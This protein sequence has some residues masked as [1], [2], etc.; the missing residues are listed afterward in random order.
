VKVV[1]AITEPRKGFVMRRSVFALAVAAFAA[2]APYVRGDDPSHEELQ[3]QIRQLQQRVAE[4]ERTQAANN[5]GVQA[6]RESV[7]KDASERSRIVPPLTP[8]TGGYDK[9]FFIRS[10]DGHYTLRPG[11]QFQ[12]RNVTTRSARSPSA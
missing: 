1:G 11:A 7:A 12:V 6:T 2:L 8:V 3:Q 10:V 9:G 4:L 5:A